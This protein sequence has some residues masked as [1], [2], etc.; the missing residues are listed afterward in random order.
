MEMQQEIISAG[1]WIVHAS[2]GIGQITGKVK[3]VIEG[4]EQ[5]YF[6]VKTYNGVYWLPLDKTDS[7]HIRPLSTERQIRRALSLIRSEPEKLPKDFRER[8]KEIKEVL[9]DVALYPMMRMI[10]DLYA[11]N[12]TKKLNYSE[13]D[14]LEK[15]KM[16]FIDEWCLVKQQDRD[17]LID[18]LSQALR[19]SMENMVTS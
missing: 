11:Q 8:G 17:I 3:K 13:G 12:R 7:D 1:D 15:M 6:R 18:R 5:E 2:Y 14:A 10:R 9:Q 19:T 16:R 4:Q